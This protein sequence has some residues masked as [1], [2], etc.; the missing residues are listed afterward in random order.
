MNA[1]SDNMIN[2][3]FRAIA[4]VFALILGSCGDGQATVAARQ[5]TQVG[6]LDLLITAQSE[7]FVTTKPVQVQNVF[8]PTG[9][10]RVSIVL[11]SPDDRAFS[12]FTARHVGEVVEVSVCGEVLASPHIMTVLYGGEFTLS[13][14]DIQH[15]IAA[16][17]A[18]GCP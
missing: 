2:E 13:G 7:R 11:L 18:D 10:P 12:A 9:R 6:E 1:V 8:D 3:V 5:A 14:T 17:L 16:Y 15:K 4:F